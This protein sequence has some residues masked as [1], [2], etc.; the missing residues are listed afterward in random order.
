LTAMTTTTRTT[1]TGLL[2]D[3]RGAAIYVEFLIIVP[4]ITLL[5]V[6]ANYMHKMGRSEIETQRLARQCAWFQA[7]SGC[8]GAAPAECKMDGPQQVAP[9]IDALAGAGTAHGG[10]LPEVAPIF[11][12][13]SS[14]E[15]VARSEDTVQEPG[16]FK[17]PVGDARK[18][19]RDRL[20]CNDKPRPVTPAQMMDVVCHG[21]LGPGGRCQ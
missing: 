6:A 7:T 8:R 2:R 5:W 16:L 4:L 19:G 9:E 14:S 12:R 13:V 10:P 1:R 11:G 15:I 17:G 18:N 3:A 21:L 20:L